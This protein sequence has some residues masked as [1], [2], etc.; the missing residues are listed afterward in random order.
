MS[1]TLADYL[2]EG[3]SGALIAISIAG[4]FRRVSNTR[5]QITV[6]KSRFFL[7]KSN[8]TTSHVR[9]DKPGPI[10]PY[11]ESSERIDPYESLSLDFDTPPQP[12]DEDDAFR[13]RTVPE[14]SWS[15]FAPTRF[16]QEDAQETGFGDFCVPPYCSRP[17]MP[18]QG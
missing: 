12:V 14:G 17:T 13:D 5:L 9:F 3:V 18:T 8:Q 6:E 1:P 7:P 10:D 4:A 15:A 2:L 11:G 16:D